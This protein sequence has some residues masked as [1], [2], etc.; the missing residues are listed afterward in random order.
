MSDLRRKVSVVKRKKCYYLR[1]W[2]GGKVASERSAKTS[3]RREAERAAI[4][5]EGRLSIEAE[6][7]PHVADMYETTVMEQHSNA[8]MANWRV[9]RRHMERLGNPALIGDVDAPLLSSIA[10]KLR[11]E[12]L[13]PESIRT[14][15]RYLSGCLV[16]AH[17]IDLIEEVPRMP[18]VPTK[19]GR[20]AKGQPLSDE[21]Y[22]GALAAC[23]HIVGAR[24]AEDWRQFLECLWLSG[25]R[26]GE[27]CGL[28]WEQTPGSHSVHSL[29]PALFLLDPDADKGG[30]SGPWPM[31]ADFAEWLGVT[32]EE[33]RRGFIVTPSGERAERL[34]SGSASRVVSSICERAGV[35][36]TA[37]D[38]RRAFCTR[39][40]RLVMPAILQQLARHAD[41]ATTMGYYVE[42]S[43]AMTAL[44]ASR[45]LQKSRNSEDYS[46]RR[47]NLRFGNERKS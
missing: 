34:T 8:H 47:L 16:W 25:L 39:W 18:K 41:I 20:K 5:L 37:H 24:R 35:V 1:I 44:E 32:P 28:R 27:V 22:R 13:A 31:A 15:M 14:Y 6:L 7:W 42:D 45:A 21:G 36:A 29:E 4:E 43:A 46:E 40:S 26:L 12:K 3:I 2:V 9:A 38:F 17:S 33:L 11:A 23:H 30:R 19:K 10:T